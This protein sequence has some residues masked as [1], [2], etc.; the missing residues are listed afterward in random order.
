[1][2]GKYQGL[3]DLHKAQAFRIASASAERCVVEIREK[4]DEL[5]RDGATFRDANEALSSVINAFREEMA[6]IKR[7]DHDK[8]LDEKASATSSTQ[9]PSEYTF[10]TAYGKVTLDAQTSQGIDLAIERMIPPAIARQYETGSPK[11]GHHHSQATV[12][13]VLAKHLSLGRDN[14]FKELGH[15]VEVG[16]IVDAALFFLYADMGV[17]LANTLIANA[18]TLP[19]AGE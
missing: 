5:M 4:I 18:L 10:E 1:M 19:F 6:N 7:F 16:D 11:N 3:F 8:V 15:P 2:N 9:D 14:A 17:P 13:A 12:R